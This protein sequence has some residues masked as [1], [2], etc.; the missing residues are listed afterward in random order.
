VLLTVVFY[1]FILA[2][3]VQCIYAFYF[4]V[5]VFRL[6]VQSRDAKPASLPVS[7]VICAKNEASNLEKNI[8]WVMAQ[9]Y[10]NEQGKPMYEVIVVNDASDDD[11]EQVLYALEQQY[12][13][14]WHVTINADTPRDLKGKKF[15]LSKGVS[16]ATYPYLLL[17]DADC[18]PSSEHWISDMIAPLGKGKEIVAGYSGYQYEGGLLNA[19]IRWETVHTFL[20]YASYALAGKPYMAVGRN[21]A[22]TKEVFL[23]AQ[24]SEV[25]N[26][27][28]SG[29]DDLLVQCCGI[30][31]NTA[32][33]ASPGSFTFSRAKST[34]GDWIRQKQRHVST[35]KY[36]KEDIKALLGGY[37]LSHGLSWLLFLILLVASPWI[38]I[39]SVVFS[40]RCIIYWSIWQATARRLGDEKLLLWIP[41]CDIGW[42]VYNLVLSPYILW[43]NKKQWK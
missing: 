27:L 5:R 40:I 14:L 2:V 3:V 28:P 16:Y 37:A 31:S 30:E 42:G 26:K 9:I 35:G 33:V 25:W 18:G 29:D 41:L 13:N 10:S 8:P 23:R 6:P 4:F 39:T 32:V 19:F 43:K 20:S 11:T 12:S 38:L 17:M 15:A 21:L 24:R 36:Y 7:V 22:C 1:I 34:W